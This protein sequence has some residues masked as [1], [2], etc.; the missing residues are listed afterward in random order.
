MKMYSTRLAFIFAFSIIYS[1]CS[2]SAH[3]VNIRIIDTQGQPLENAVVSLPS[4]PKQAGTTIAVMDQIE[5]QFSPRVLT[6]SQGQAVSFPNSDNVRHHVYSFSKTKPF[7]IKLYSGTSTSPVVFDSPGIIVLGC[8]IHDN[9][10]GYIL[11]KDG[12]WSGI[13]AKDGIISLPTL[14]E[15][16]A[17]T[18]WHPLMSDD[19]KQI[20]KITL[21]AKQLTQ[22]DTITITLD[23]TPVANKKGNSFKDRFKRNKKTDSYDN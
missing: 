15:D 20:K 3:A 12:Y 1:M 14:T 7:E 2:Y 16:T 17:A 22:S 11:V 9:M 21:S 6:V 4:V 10:V 18:I 8:N 13:S 19:S 5:Q 23:V